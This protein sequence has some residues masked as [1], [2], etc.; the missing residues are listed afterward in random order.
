MEK[1]I[2]IA[3]SQYGVKEIPGDQDNPQILK[4]FDDMGFDGKKLKDETAW[5]SIF[6]NW[7]AM[8]S[9]LPYSGKL[10]ARSWLKIG[11]KV[12][13]PQLGDVVVFWRGNPDSWMGHVG[14]YIRETKNWIYVLGGNQSN[15]VK[16]AAYPKKRLL[17]YR[18][19]QE[20]CK[21]W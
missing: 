8:K 10:D 18:R 6:L 17:E 3:L 15:Q 4:Y 11:R 14:F 7:V 1:I 16:I 19:L 12:E 5:C 20:A 2:E 13:N 21:E 9:G